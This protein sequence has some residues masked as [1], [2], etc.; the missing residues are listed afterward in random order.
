M[1]CCSSRKPRWPVTDQVIYANPIKLD[2]W[3]P[4]DYFLIDLIFPTIA[5]W[6]FATPI[7]RHDYSRPSQPLQISYS[8]WTRPNCLV[9]LVPVDLIDLKTCSKSS[10]NII[11]STTVNTNC[12]RSE[13]VEQNAQVLYGYLSL[14]YE[15]YNYSFY[16]HIT[17]LH[18]QW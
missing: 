12:L 14:S 2:S 17:Y 8:N 1:E 9:R 3:L 15:S 7:F 4:N 18:D 5:S 11:K 13:G 10:F 16:L 6:L